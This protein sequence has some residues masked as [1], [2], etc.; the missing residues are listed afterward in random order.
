MPNSNRILERQMPNSNMTLERQ[1]TSVVTPEGGFAIVALD[2]RE[3]LREMFPPKA[4][5]DLVDDAALRAFKAS[6]AKILTPHASGVLLD[7]PYAVTNAAPPT[8][9]ADGCGLILAADK[10]HSVRGA[11]VLSSSLDTDVNLDFIRATGAAA[12]KLLVIWRRGIDHDRVRLVERFLELAEAAGVAS[13]IEG[14]VRPALGEEWRSAAER[15][16]AIIEAATDLSRGAGVYKA[17]V[18]G[19]V[20]GDLSR[21]REHAKSLTE[22]VDGPWVVLSSGVYEPDF[23]DAVTESCAGGARGFLAGR[24][25]WADTVSDP[26]P[27]SA[28]ATRSVERLRRLLEIVKRSREGVGAG[29]R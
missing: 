5:G 25:I 22:V 19:Y 16:A 17:E 18:P 2:Q 23:A 29:E 8:M 3:S 13:F 1:L 6:A 20:R 15:H 26:D 12:I 9:I 28:L 11:G 21:V 27:E 4:G 24:A 10:L 7:R 14:I